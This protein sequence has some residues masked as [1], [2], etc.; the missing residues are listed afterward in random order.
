MK[1]NRISDLPQLFFTQESMYHENELD[2][3]IFLYV[4]S[5]TNLTFLQI[6]KAF[7]LWV[8]RFGIEF[9]VIIPKKIF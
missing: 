5:R 2:L 1:S 8:T 7:E 3:P 9:S 4:Y 6:A